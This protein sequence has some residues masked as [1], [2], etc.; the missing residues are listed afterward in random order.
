MELILE[1]KDCSEP[2]DPTHN[3]SASTINMDSSSISQVSIGKE[4]KSAQS[5][6]RVTSEMKRKMGMRN[7]NTKTPHGLALNITT[8]RMRCT[9]KVKD[10]LEATAGSVY[11]KTT[12]F[13]H[14]IY[15]DSWKSGNFYPSLSTKWDVGNVEPTITIPLQSLDNLDNLLI[16]TTLATKTKM[17]KKLVLGT[18]VIGGPSAG[19]AI[20]ESGAEHMATLR[21]TALNERVAMWHCYQ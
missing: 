15:I 3:E 21:E 11:V 2:I 19:S 17:A 16:K 6:N 20:S 4:G 5:W 14:G 13:E 7:V 10:E 9:N 8:S 18:V 1:I 12:V